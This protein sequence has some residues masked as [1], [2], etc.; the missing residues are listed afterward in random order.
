M[1]KISR[2]L[3]LMALVIVLIVSFS[4]LPSF[5]ANAIGLAWGFARL[6]QAG[7]LKSR[8]IA[9]LRGACFA[10]VYG[11]R[12]FMQ[13]SKM[14]ENDN[15]PLPPE[16]IPFGVCLACGAWVVLIALI[17]QGAGVKVV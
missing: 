10:T 3:V 11:M 15:V 2:K 5:A 7:Q 4:A 13:V 8:M 16:A 1:R 6:Y 9:L 14:P 12:A 17:L